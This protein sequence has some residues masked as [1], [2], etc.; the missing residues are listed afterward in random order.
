MNLRSLSLL[1]FGYT[2]VEGLVVNILYPATWPFLVKDVFILVA[3]GQLLSQSHLSSGSLRRL[4]APMVGFMV[5]LGLFLLVPSPAVTLF[6]RLV[7]LK[8]RLFYIPLMYVGY[9]AIRN[10][11][12]IVDLMKVMAWTAIP[13]AL[14]GIYLFFTGPMGLAQLGANYS[15]IITS[16]AGA[17]GESFW[18]VPGTFTSPG[19]FGLYLFATG[20]MLSAMLFV[21]GAPARFRQLIIVACVLLTGALLVCGS[22]TPLLLWGGAS[23]VMLAATG[24]LAG[25]AMWGAG[26][27]GVLSVAFIYFGAGVRDRVG[28]IASW[29]HVERF[30]TTYFGQL[31]LPLLLQSPLGFGLGRATLAA[32]HFSDWNQLMLMESYFGVLVAETGILG[33]GAFVWLVIA[34]LG[35]VWS[36]WRRMQSS[37]YAIP[38]F[39]SAGVFLLVAALLPVN[40]AIDSAPGNL[41]F[42]F[43]LGFAIKLHDMDLALRSAPQPGLRSLPAPNYAHR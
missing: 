3:Y 39:A 18:R 20:A 26:A 43:F 34:A 37:P 29:E 10:D 27:Y 21:P 28:S 38:F 2:C 6:G 22:R 9:H 41:Y 13:T 35:L 4:T 5:I 12:D 36:C 1:I 11:D 33:L 16:T 42:W 19:Q 24:R 8:Q 31:F 25:I 7:A 17:A 15:A 40:T 23:L 32:R 30:R 14:F